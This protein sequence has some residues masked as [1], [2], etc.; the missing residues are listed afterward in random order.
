[1]AKLS[2]KEIEEL[3]KEIYPLLASV[4]EFKFK[5]FRRMVRRNVNNYPY[6]TFQKDDGDTEN[7]YLAQS[8]DA[9]WETGAVLT[10][11][12]LKDLGLRRTVNKNKEMRIKVCM[13]E[14]FENIEELLG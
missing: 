2:D 12:E 4:K 3:D 10:D 6:L 5:G 9:R 7:V 11:D 13:N 14:P 8:L 1:M